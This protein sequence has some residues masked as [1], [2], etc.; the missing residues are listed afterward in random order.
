M[1]IWIVSRGRCPYRMRF[2]TQREAH[3][4]MARHAD[5]KPDTTR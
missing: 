5:E 3:E 2:R 1:K 4:D